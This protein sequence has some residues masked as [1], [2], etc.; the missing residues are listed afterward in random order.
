[1][2]QSTLTEKWKQKNLRPAR[3]CEQHKAARRDDLAKEA[4]TQN[5]QLSND[6]TLRHKVPKT[7]QRTP[8]RFT[9]A[10]DTA[11]PLKERHED[12][13]K[14]RRNTRRSVRETQERPYSPA[15]QLRSRIENMPSDSAMSSS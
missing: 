10:M 2:A 11:P 6:R 1:M 9:A 12:T 3:S 13:P 7:R 8:H 14:S 5:A 15:S 4:I